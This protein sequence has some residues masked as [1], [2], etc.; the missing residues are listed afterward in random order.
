MVAFLPHPELTGMWVRCHPSALI[1]RCPACRSQPGEP[2]RGTEGYWTS[3]DGH[4]DRREAYQHATTR[5]TAAAGMIFDLQ[6]RLARKPRRD[7]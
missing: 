1:V 2:C 7:P 6:L 4:V 5:L 3:G